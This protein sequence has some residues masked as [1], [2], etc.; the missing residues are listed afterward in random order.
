MFSIGVIQINFRKMYTGKCAFA[1]V[2]PNRSVIFNYTLDQ[3]FPI[4]GL[5]FS[6]NNIL[7]FFP[8]VIIGMRGM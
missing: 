1:K 2:A 6:P 4:V 3:D 5:S 7:V 8:R